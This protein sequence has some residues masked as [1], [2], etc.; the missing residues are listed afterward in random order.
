MPRA[1]VVPPSLRRLAARQEGLVGVAQCRE[2]RM[3][4]RQVGALVRQGRWRRVMLGVLDTAIPSGRDDHPLDR[5]RRRAA[6][7]GPIAFPGAVATGVAA[8]VLHGAQGAPVRVLPE[9][10]FPDGSPRRSRKPVRIRREPLRRWLEVDGIPCVLPELALA[11]AV[12]ELDRRD[13]VA[14]MDSARHRRLVTDTELGRAVEAAG[15]RRGAARCAAWWDE[16]DPRAESPVESAARLVTSDAGFPP[17]ALQL[18]IHDE[19]GRFLARPDLAWILPDG[20]I[21]PVELDGRDVHSTPEA[22]F[23]DRTRQN[24]L[25][26]RGA[27]MLRYTGRDVTSGVVAG[28]VGRLLDQVGW[29]PR[30]W[31]A[32]IPFVLST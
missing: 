28:E 11:Q 30:P 15:G 6:I 3:T 12:P 23:T 10:T 4:D 19:R 8:L 16:S 27:R 5:R 26:G 7:I 13:A 22:V 24:A 32:D 17:D 31:P 25:V 1:I 20:G 2:H 9:V 18:V 14:L 21:V 29:M